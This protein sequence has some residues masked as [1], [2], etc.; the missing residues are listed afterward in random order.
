[1]LEMIQVKTMNRADQID[2]RY[3]AVLACE[4]HAFARLLEQRKAK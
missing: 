3:L 4:F 1:M 2:L